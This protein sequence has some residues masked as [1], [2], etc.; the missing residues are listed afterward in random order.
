MN[1]L[2]QFVDDIDCSLKIKF[3]NHVYCNIHHSVSPRGEKCPDC[4]HK[5][6]IDDPW[7]PSVNQINERVFYLNKC[8]KHSVRFRDSCT[9]CDS[10]KLKIKKSTKDFEN[11]FETIFEIK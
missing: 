2:L 1:I 6:L 3:K 9:I 4:Q 11:H 5:G 7:I 10:L 8:S